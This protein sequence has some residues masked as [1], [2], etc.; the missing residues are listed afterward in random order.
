MP[1]NP[2]VYNQFKAIRY[3][4]FFDLI[5]MISEEGLKTGIDIGCGTGE[6]T[7]ILAQRFEKA[8]F[9]GIDPSP[10]MLAKSKEFKNSNLNFRQATVEDFTTS[11]VKK[12]E[13][14]FS[15][16]ALQWSDNHEK[17]FPQLIALLTD[18]GQFAIQMPVQ[19]ENVLNR[20]L[21]DLVQEKPFVD[22]LKGW[23]RAAPLL[24][25]DQYAQLM[26]ENGL[27]DLQII[28]KVYPILTETPDQLFDFISG[29]ALIPYMERLSKA[30]QEQLVTEFKIRIQ[31]EFKQF[32]ALYAF[33]RLLLYGRKK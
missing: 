21:F 2:E 30:E 12:W 11:D 7:A 8:R 31:K 17:L 28:Q 9:S 29:S 32:P 18:K 3:Q 16:A 20:I 1:W 6:Q 13:L 23:K 19:K 26:F 27:E 25:I 10:D 24:S 22:F 15:N 4:P 14:I 5:A 33:K